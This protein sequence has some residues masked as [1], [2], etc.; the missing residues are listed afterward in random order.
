MLTIVTGPPCGGKTTHVREHAEPGDLVLD[1]DAIAHAMG[2]PREQIEWG[3]DHPAI[4]SARM[5]RAHVLNALLNHRLIANAWVIDTAP[6]GAMRAQYQR[7]GART[8]TI[9][10]G[11]DVCLER[12][13]NRHPSTRD[14]IVNWYAKHAPGPSAALGIFGR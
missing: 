5:A 7:A 12:A 8:I 9:D 14:G 3:D 13:A 1:L 11:R 4:Q 2:Y 10:P 6:A